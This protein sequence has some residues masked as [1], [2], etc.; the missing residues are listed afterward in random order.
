MAD[1]FRVLAQST[2]SA[3]TLTDIYAV[4]SATSAVVSSIIV[5]NRGTTETS[6]RLSI[7]VAGASDTNKQYL[8]YDTPIAA[9]DTFVATIGVSLGSADVIRAQ[10]AAAN[11]SFNV[12]GVEIT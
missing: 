7:A 11:L 2:P 4:P 10:A 5:C 8:Y 1:T 12:F 3:A 6:F 9:N